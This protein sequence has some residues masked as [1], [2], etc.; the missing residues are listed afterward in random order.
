M[1]KVVWHTNENA[2]MFTPRENPGYNKLTQDATGVI[3][4]WLQN[5]W[6]DT[7]AEEPLL[8]KEASPPEDKPSAEDK[9]ATKDADMEETI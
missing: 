8:L 4:S 7:S 5:D 6:Y 2:D 3:H 9:P 1:W